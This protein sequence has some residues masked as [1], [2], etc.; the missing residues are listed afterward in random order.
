MSS[1][2]KYILKDSWGHEMNILVIGQ[3]DSGRT[4][5]GTGVC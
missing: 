2:V 4:V 1:V 5:G 3:L